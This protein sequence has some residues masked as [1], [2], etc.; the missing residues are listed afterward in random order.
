VATFVLVHGAFRGGW[1]W[2]LVR[3]ALLADGH[4]VR[5][6]SLTGMGDRRHLGGPGR[7]RVTLAT[8]VDDVALLCELDDLHDVVLVGHSQGGLVT[9]AASSRLADR[10]AR[11]VHLDAP[12]PRDGERG[13]DLNP[14][15]VPAPDPASVDLDAWL[16]GRE[17]EPDPEGRE[18]GMTPA[19]AAWVNERLCATPI[20]PSFDPVSLDA[21]G[22][23]VPVTH[24]FCSRTPSTYPAWSTRARLDADGTPYEVLDSEHDAPLTA[25][26]LV[27]EALLRAAAPS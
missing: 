12:V 18:G 24:L 22:A 7:P 6:P 16:P 20:A 8:W 26:R 14:P 15:G 13:V 19:L 3:A 2:R 23:A 25:P 5:T 10:L 27:V 21:A 1:S 11:V 9:T 17:V 4:D